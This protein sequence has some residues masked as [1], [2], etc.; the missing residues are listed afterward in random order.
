MSSIPVVAW[1]P[2]R[3]PQWDHPER[4][5]IYTLNRDCFLE[6]LPRVLASLDDAFVGCAVELGQPPN[7]V[8]D[9]MSQKSFLA[10][11]KLCE[12]IAVSGNVAVDVE[13]LKQVNKT[14]EIDP[15][16][17]R[18]VAA[19]DFAVA[20]ER[21]LI[22]SELAY[23]SCIDAMDGLVLAESKPT[24]PVHAKGTFRSLRFLN[25]EDL[26]WAPVEDVELLRVVAWARR[27]GMLQ[28]GLSTTRMQ[29]ALA[30][31]THVIGLTWQRDGDVLFRAMQGLEAFYC[32]GVGDLRK[33]L[34]EKIQLWLGAWTDKK[35]IVG[36]LYDLRSKFV[37]GSA[38]L[39]YWNHHADPW[40]ED[41]STMVDFSRGVSFAVRLLVATLQKCVRDDVVDVRWSYTVEPRG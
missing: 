20:I 21:V 28:S 30:A 13:R 8:L 11:T 32:D 27:V 10:R 39:E 14:E 33:Q 38:P 18:G 37:H 2:I 19:S 24:Y 7:E 35:N 22:L 4:L 16:F 3:T 36:Q 12:H 17:I 9:W 6:H 26:S 25:P 34:S 15:E 29:R 40:S 5:P 23:P 41:E 1:L 31:Y